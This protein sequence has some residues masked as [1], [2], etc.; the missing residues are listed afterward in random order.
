MKKAKHIDNIKDHTFGRLLSNK[1]QSL[2]LDD[3]LPLETIARLVEGRISGK[4]RQQI[5][6]HISVCDNCYEVF[7]LSDRLRS[8]SYPESKKGDRIRLYR[9]LALAAS[10]SALVISLVIVYQ[11]GQFKKSPALSLEKVDVTTD[12]LEDS[13]SRFRGKERVSI[14]KSGK[15]DQPKKSLKKGV[16]T[17]TNDSKFKNQLVQDSRPEKKEIPP[18]KTRTKKTTQ[19]ATINPVEREAFQATESEGEKRIEE[20]PLAKQKSDPATT[21]GRQDSLKRSGTDEKA[22]LSQVI[23]RYT[24]GNVQ[25]LHQFQKAK[26]KNV[27]EEI[28]EYDPDG[29]NTLIQNVLTGSMTKM[30]YH[31]NGHLKF[32]QEFLQGRPHGTWIKWDNQGRVIE[33]QIYKKGKLIKT[34]Q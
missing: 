34:L 5:M 4:Q 7:R 15:K 6:S 27:L 11:T 19:P 26:G 3:C 9:P 28:L 32:R 2:P 22:G 10:I 12:T 1:L 23:N 18:P 21:S 17:K 29:R 16:T 20:K 31:P 30:D 14:D 13:E 8:E 33:K 25:T 24:N